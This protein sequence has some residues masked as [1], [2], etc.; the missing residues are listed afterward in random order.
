MPAPRVISLLHV[1]T[2]AQDVARQRTDIERLKR[3]YNL[4][5]IRTLELVG[6]SGTATLTNEQVQ[7]VLRDV[8]QPGVAGVAASAVDRVF[9][10]KRGGDCAIL[11]AFQDA[12]KAL[13]TVRD[14]Y[15]E[16]WT[17]EGWER[18]MAAAVRAGSEW[19]EI[20]RRSM[21]GKEE[22]RNLGRHVNGP[23]SLPR[24]VAFDKATGKWSYLEPDCSRVARMF[25]LFLDGW[26]LHAIAAEVG[27]GWTYQGVKNTLRN[28]IWAFGER[29]YPPDGRREQPLVV[30]VI[31]K[32]LISAEIWQH[33]QDILDRRREHWCRTKRPSRFLLS[34]LLRCQCGKV[35]YLRVRSRN[36]SHDTYLCSSRYPSGIG[37]GMRRVWRESVDATVV[38]IIQDCFQ[39]PERLI[40]LLEA[41]KQRALEVEL[42]APQIKMDANPRGRLESKRE[43]ILEQRA[44]GLISREQ[45]IERVAAVDRELAALAQPP[46][47]LP[48]IPPAILFQAIR[49]I[50]L[51]F[52]RHSFEHQRAILQSI[53]REITLANSAIISITLKG[54]KVRSH[55]TTPC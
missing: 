46:Q 28:R 51:E 30:K 12:R 36:S 19:R 11:D 6:V 4:E 22:K 5:V 34:G 50:F 49:N 29:V 41:I 42:A 44:D 35:C 33:V 45:C 23:R 52:E 38:E 54:V 48:E 53:I 17:D 7:Q 3:A 37:C 2:D 40:P 43:R 8:Q 1:S 20:R 31:D 18:A 55:S 32:P 27:G 15:I 13:W 26:S 39:S 10:P 14:G 24:G 47:P 25:Q 9:R 16:P 21:D